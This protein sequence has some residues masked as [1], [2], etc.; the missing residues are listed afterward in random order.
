MIYRRMKL[1]SPAKRV[2][3]LYQDTIYNYTKYKNNELWG[4]PLFYLMFKIFIEK[5]LFE[6]FLSNEY[7]QDK[8]HL[9]NIA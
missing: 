1:D 9:F 4:T 7:S 3:D 6:E 5:G 2:I 8:A